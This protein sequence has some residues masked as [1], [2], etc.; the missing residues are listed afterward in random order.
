M[1]PPPNTHQGARGGP[2][3]QSGGQEGDRV[4][5]AGDQTSYSR[6]QDI[7]LVGF[8]F[9]GGLPEAYLA[10]RGVQLQGPQDGGQS[11]FLGARLL[12]VRKLEA[13]SGTS[14]LRP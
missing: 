3:S 5:P 10:R 7:F 11:P 1:G 8:T 13:F 4:L 14:G 2:Q 6:F 9:L 12:R